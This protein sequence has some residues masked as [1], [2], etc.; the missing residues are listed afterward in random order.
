M[1]GKFDSSGDLLTFEPGV[2]SSS[3]AGARY[4]LII[5]AYEVSV[6]RPSSYAQPQIDARRIAI[7]SGN[8]TSSWGKE[9]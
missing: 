3:Q 8:G 4:C 5:P 6:E 9:G 1:F 2:C 7:L